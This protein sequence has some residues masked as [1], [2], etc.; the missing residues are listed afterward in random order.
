MTTAGRPP[1]PGPVRAVG[2]KS[3]EQGLGAG[4]EQPTRR[5]GKGD[6]GPRTRSQRTAERPFAFVVRTLF[7]S[8]LHT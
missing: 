1:C 4:S 8:R 5:D 7:C 6:E 2:G 3:L